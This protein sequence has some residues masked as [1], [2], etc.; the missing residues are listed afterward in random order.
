MTVSLSEQSG[1]K[2]P[3]HI[4]RKRA[5]WFEIMYL[6][7]RGR[8]GRLVRWK[9]QTGCCVFAPPGQTWM[10]RAALPSSHRDEEAEEEEGGRAGD[11]IIKKKKLHSFFGK[12][13]S[14]MILCGLS[15]AGQTRRRLH[16]FLPGIVNS[17][18]LIIMLSF[19]VIWKRK[20]V[21]TARGFFLSLSPCAL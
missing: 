4:W 2:T 14:L 17:C 8:G 15:A 7:S 5:H 20:L 18:L 3:L 11:K 21:L 19:I 16:A 6:Q 10:Q 1:T 12:H 9:S 13:V